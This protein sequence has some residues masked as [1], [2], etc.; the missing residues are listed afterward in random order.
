M[1]TQADRAELQM[2]ASAC[3]ST[4]LSAGMSPRSARQWLIDE[5]TRTALRLLDGRVRAAWLADYSVFVD[6]ALSRPDEGHRHVPMT[7]GE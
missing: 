7:R 3:V 2:V 5:A 6:A 1:P 4:A